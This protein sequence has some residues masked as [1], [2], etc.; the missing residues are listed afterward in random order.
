LKN[1]QSTRREHD[2]IGEEGIYY[3]L[4]QHSPSAM[5]VTD[6][7]GQVIDCNQESERLLARKR[8]ELAGGPLKELEGRDLNDLPEIIHVSNNEKKIFIRLQ[9]LDQDRILLHLWEEDSKEV[10]RRLASFPEMNPTPVLEF[11]MDGTLTY[12]NQTSRI[13]F[14]NLELNDTAHP[15]IASILEA[16]PRFRPGNLRFLIDEFSHRGNDYEINMYLVRESMA[17]R[18]YITDIT[19][20]REARSLESRAEKMTRA[21]MS[22]SLII[23]RNLDFDEVVRETLSAARSIIGSKYGLFGRLKNGEVVSFYQSGLDEEE[24]ARINGLPSAREGLLAEVVASDEPVMINDIQSH[25]LF[26]GLPEN[27]PPVSRLLAA[28][29][30]RENSVLGVIILSERED[31]LPFDENDRDILQSLCLH[32]SVAMENSLLYEKVKGF[33]QEL[34]RRVEESTTELKKALAL[35]EEAGRARSEFIANVSHELRTPMNSIIGFSDVLMEASSD[36]L[37]GDQREYLEQIR[38]SADHLMEMINDIIEISRYESGQISVSPEDIYMTDM[39]RSIEKM[40]AR[41]VD[42]KELD[43][44]IETD[45]LLQ[46]RTVRTDANLLKRILKIMVM[47]AVKFSPHGGTCRVSAEDR[48]KGFL[49]LVGDDGSGVPEGKEETIFQ[50][51]GQSSTGERWSQ[52][53]IGL[54]LARKLARLLGGDLRASRPDNERG[55]LLNLELPK[56]KEE[57]KGYRL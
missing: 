28:P 37:T 19:H 23:S 53:G 48:P 27:H 35:A 49:I 55:S 11:D 41:Y 13:Q 21:L 46:N 56:E 29:L 4:F 10:N 24:L 36:E 26:K 30:N 5:I 42:E 17:I 15:V 18:C 44:S 9:D 22:A 12:A 52:A 33:N 57:N 7:K 39:L 40:V 50:E 47:N 20:R 1:G 14:P 38:S 54:S 2:E 3:E 25:T 43:F 8:S 34:E 51:F 6:R 32:A 31:D 45:T 16:I